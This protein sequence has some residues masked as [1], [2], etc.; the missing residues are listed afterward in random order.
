MGDKEFGI[1][2]KTVMNFAREIKTAQENSSA[3]IAIVVGG[4]NI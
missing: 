2:P 4:G 3:E 1:D